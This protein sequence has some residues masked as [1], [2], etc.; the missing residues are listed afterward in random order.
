MTP[1]ERVV[2]E[3]ELIVLEAAV[4]DSNR[5]VLRGIAGFAGWL[6]VAVL[7]VLLFVHGVSHL[8]Q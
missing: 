1:A 7:S 2:A 6:A 5:R 4:R 3:A 8:I